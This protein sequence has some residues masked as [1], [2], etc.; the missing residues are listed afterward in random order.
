MAI[1]RR[2][3]LRADIHAECIGTN[4]HESI[5]HEARRI[6][7]IEGWSILITRP[8]RAVT[9]AHDAFDVAPQWI[10]RERLTE[11][12]TRLL[13]CVRK[14][15]CLPEEIG[16]STH[17]RAIR[18]AK[19]HRCSERERVRRWVV[20]ES[21]HAR[22]KIR[23]RERT[24]ERGVAID[25]DWFTV[26]TTIGRGEKGDHACRCIDRIKPEAAE[27]SE[28][29]ALSRSGCA[30]R[31]RIHQCRSGETR[32]AERVLLRS[33]WTHRGDRRCREI[34]Y[35]NR[36]VL[37]QCD[38][39]ALRVSGYR[40]IL[41]FKVLSDRRS[42]ETKRHNRGI[43]RSCWKCI[44]PKRDDCCRGDHIGARAKRDDRNGAFRIDRI[45]RVGLPFICRDDLCSIGRE[46]HHVWK[47]TNLSRTKERAVRVEEHNL[48]R[49]R[50][51]DGSDG[52]SEYAV[53]E[54]DA[55]HAAAEGKRRDG[56][57]CDGRRRQREIEDIDCCGESVDDERAVC[58][59]IECDD[60]CA[61][62]VVARTSSSA[63]KLERN[64]RLRERALRCER[65]GDRAETEE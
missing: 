5:E 46:A 2:E 13:I 58:R 12:I 17:R 62:D 19:E 15:R 48:T 25:I 44:E 42:A 60:F 20:G 54:R 26:W 43:N 27:S 39:R 6:K 47:R 59:R 10:E 61:G 4:R 36:A 65:C 29:D 57:Q 18:L 11:E 35:C 31:W 16:E 55:L 22:L 51:W 64:C 33:Q 21:A 3:R 50:V 24:L 45:T 34:E 1:H 41:W 8:E 40:D 63:E 53:L 52:G 30:E 23:K 28:C 9:C 49:V 32:D 14:S 37:L 38:P 7:V 56:S